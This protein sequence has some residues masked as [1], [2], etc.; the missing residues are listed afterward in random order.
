MYSL[1]ANRSAWSIDIRDA[2]S[3]GGT[4]AGC[5]AIVIFACYSFGRNQGHKREKMRHMRL[6]RIPSIH[7][8]SVVCIWIQEDRDAYG[9]EGGIRLR[10]KTFTC[11]AYGRPVA[12]CSRPSLSRSN[13]CNIE[14]HTL[15]VRGIEPEDAIKHALCLLETAQPPQA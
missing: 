15:I 6:R 11:R 14:A 13:R 12:S 5:L 1:E 4:E 9:G 8:S 3:V 2:T 10:A 7:L